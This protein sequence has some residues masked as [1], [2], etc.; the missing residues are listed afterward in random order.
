MVLESGRSVCGCDD[1]EPAGAHIGER[2][3]DHVEIHA[4]LELDQLAVRARDDA[5]DAVEEDFVGEIHVGSSG[6]VVA[7]TGA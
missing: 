6:S 3:A 4:V 5:Y 7:A 1:A 2:N